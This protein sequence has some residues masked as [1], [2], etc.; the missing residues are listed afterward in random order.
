ML[1][2]CCSSTGGELWSPCNIIAANE[3]AAQLRKAGDVAPAFIFYRL[4]PSLRQGIS[5]KIPLF[6]R[7]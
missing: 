2:R 1:V 5:L 6:L 3:K 4:D 7:T